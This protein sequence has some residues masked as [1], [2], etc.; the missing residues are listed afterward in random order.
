MAEN[1]PPPIINAPSFSP[2]QEASGLSGLLSGSIGKALQ[3]LDCCLPARVISFDRASNRVTVEPM[4][5]ITS[6]GNDQIQMA[7]IDSIPVFL[8]GGAGAFISFD[9]K[10]NDLGWIIANDQDISLFLQT[11]ESSAENT[12]RNHSFSDALFLPDLMHDYYLSGKEGEASF[13]TKEGTTYITLSES[14]INIQVSGAFT[15]VKDADLKGEKDITI[16]KNSLAK[17]DGNI[18]KLLED[19]T[20][21]SKGEG[22]GNFKSV[23]IGDISCPENTLTEIVT[24]VA[25]WNEVNNENKGEPQGEGKGLTLEGDQ[26]TIDMPKVV[27]NSQSAQIKS[28]QI[29]ITSAVNVTGDINVTGNVY[30]TSEIKGNQ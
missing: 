5:K 6:T 20:L 19:V 22:K 27:I 16:P 30:A 29:E 24:Q 28:S 12:R 9:L 11:Y 17:S 3:N 8:F 10:Q 23:V 13:Q 2:E 4:Y 7:Q 21:D 25:G 14:K 26:I 1:Q 15:Y 18:F